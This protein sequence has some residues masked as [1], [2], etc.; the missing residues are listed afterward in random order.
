MWDIFV[1]FIQLKKY[2]TNVFV[3]YLS[4]YLCLILPVHLTLVSSCALCL[5]CRLLK[6]VPWQTSFWF[7]QN[8]LPQHNI[9]NLRLRCSVS[10]WMLHPFSVLLLARSFMHWPLF[11]FP[12]RATP[13]RI[14]IVWPRYQPTA[15]PVTETLVLLFVVI[16]VCLFVCLFRSVRAYVKKKLNKYI[17][18][19]CIFASINKLSTQI[20][21]HHYF[22]V[23]G[24]WN[25]VPLVL[26]CL[27]GM[28]K[29][30]AVGWW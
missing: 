1:I 18:S 5:L 2:D 11:N 21:A 20:N 25:Q 28:L 16:V 8:K 7:V 3:I 19:V 24:H 6:C 23:L 26:P 14:C 10:I 13:T 30:T 22:M 15:Q 29:A 12:C 4:V 9:A 27:L 17:T